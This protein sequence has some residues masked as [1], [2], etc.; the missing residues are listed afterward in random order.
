M[1]SAVN[2]LY[3]GSQFKNKI[4]ELTGTQFSVGISVRGGA[5]A[6]SVERHG[7]L[8]DGTFGFRSA[9][10]TRNLDNWILIRL[11]DSYLVTVVIKAEN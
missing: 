9:P 8:S 2:R 3:F 5:A 6:V 4:G 7:G 1:W 10:K 11:F